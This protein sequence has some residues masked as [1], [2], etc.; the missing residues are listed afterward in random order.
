MPD[1]SSPRTNRNASRQNRGP[2][3]RARSAA[4]S[5]GLSAGQDFGRYRVQKVLGRGAMGA[6]Y[7]AEDT[8]LRRPVALKIPHFPDRNPEI[9]QRF[10]REAQVAA[11]LRQAHIC[12]VYDVGE[13]DGVHYISMA[14][15]PGHTLR[16]ELKSGPLPIDRTVD[17]MIKLADALSVAHQQG[18]VHRDLKPDNVMIDEQH[19]E[20]VI[21]DFGLAIQHQQDD[22]E[23]LSMQGALIG[24]PAYMPPE[25]TKAQTAAPNPQSDIYSLGVMF[26]EMLT[27][28]L[29]FSGPP[30]TVL[31][32]LLTEQPPRPGEI[33]D[34]NP[35]LEAICLK[36]MAKQPRGRHDSMAD[37]SIALKTWQ[38]QTDTVNLMPGLPSPPDV[39]GTHVNL[40][41]TLAASKTTL[42]P[43]GSPRGPRRGRKVARSS[44]SRR[45]RTNRTTGFP[46][47]LQLG[48]GIPLVVA[49]ILFLRNMLVERNAQIPQTAQQETD[50]D[51]PSDT[52]DDQ[53]TPPPPPSSARKKPQPLQPVPQSPFGKDN[54][55]AAIV[56]ESPPDN[57]NLIPAPTEVDPFAQAIRFF[58]SNT[59]DGWDVTPHRDR[60]RWQVDAG[61][62][63][64]PVYAVG[65]DARSTLWTQQMYDN[66]LLRLEF[67]LD[68]NT[69]A[70]ILLR[71]PVRAESKILLSC[72]EIALNGQP[73]GGLPEGETPN[74]GLWG[75]AQPTKNPYRSD[76]WNSLQIEARGSL[77][78]VNI[79]SQQVLD[80]DLNAIHAKRP[81]DRLLVH[82]GYIGLQSFR[83]KVE[84]RNV[85]LA[86]LTE[87]EVPAPARMSPYPR[88]WETSQA[89]GHAGR[90]IRSFTMIPK[91]HRAL[92]GDDSGQIRF[93][94]ASDGTVREISGNQLGGFPRAA[95]ISTDPGGRA[96]YILEHHP[97]PTGQRSPEQTRISQWWLDPTL[98]W[99]STSQ[100]LPRPANCIL[101]GPQG[102]DCLY[103][104]PF[105][106]GAVMSARP[107]EIW[108]IRSLGETAVPAPPADQ[109]TVVRL[110]PDGN[111][112]VIGTAGGSIKLHDIQKN[113]LVRV[114]GR[115]KGAVSDLAL[116]PDGLRLASAGADK[117]IRLW[118]L[119]TM[120]P[121]IAFSAGNFLPTRVCFLHDEK[122]LA[123]GH[124]SGG[125][126]VH[127]ID[128]GAMATNQLGH[129]AAVSGLGSTPDGRSLITAGGDGIVRVWSL[130]DFRP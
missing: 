33:V 2:S 115:H 5:Q 21:M 85:D 52:A 44:A 116:S 114:L 15:I 19:G 42:P 66:F 126:T 20:P 93:W 112:I 101:A 13:V 35:Q 123:I 18:I 26:Y 39:E 62:L 120:Q 108:P 92:T 68:N 79:N 27:G 8:T 104:G 55:P 87:N 16:A 25:Q 3:S 23:R 97:L 81:A 22:A 60:G 129:S 84:Y 83:G 80:V 65:A 78:R 107:M 17:V 125:L 74:G 61:L 45:P 113:R 119:T 64:P 91:T 32:K 90:V 58:R 51:G 111:Q 82:R 29:P 57:G 77:L 71:S 47:L 56:P 109:T 100:L 130:A 96:V 30:L 128:T 54:P 110:L 76:E 106:M 6:V 7:L 43:G 67:K 118:N 10:Y 94:D 14:F 53:I 98:N 9:L 34:V 31:A 102:T 124:S 89:D 49:A 73:A 121:E 41:V 88:L 59:L 4:S 36:M 127:E 99:R 70:G 24:T 95:A 40:H 28:R 48:I 122:R 75:F 1:S 12:P 86:E 46:L 50:L 11:G 69:D 72:L 103:A 38:S 105:G 63:T 37:V 117:Q